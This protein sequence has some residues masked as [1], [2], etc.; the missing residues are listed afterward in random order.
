MII[1]ITG[2]SHTGKTLLAQKMLETYK[3]P[4]LSIDHL[5]MGLIR[6]GQTELTPEDDP[7]LTA[8]LWPIVR[9]SIKTAIENRQNLIVE[10]CYIPF[11]W[12]NDF[13]EAYLKEIK[14]I[15][16]IMAEQYIKQHFSDIVNHA[17]EI[18]YRQDDKDCT[19]ERLLTDNLWYLEMCRRYELPYLLIESDYRTELNI[20]ME[21]I[22]QNRTNECLIIK[23]DESHLPGLEDFYGKVTRHL[24]NTVNYPKWIPGVY[25]GKE[26]ISRAIANQVQYMC[27]YENTIV[28]AFLLNDNPQGDYTKGDW[29]Q[30]LQEGEYLVIHTLAVLPEMSGKGVGRRMVDYCIEKAK[31]GGFKALRMDVVPENIPARKLYE[32]AGFTFAGEKDLQRNLEEIPLFALYEMNF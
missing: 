32:K 17:S 25:P 20:R 28:G 24:N 27:L 30:S 31:A 9:E 22:M 26:S 16:L 14:Y 7:K 3:F 19:A 4:Y 13:E 11:D 5:K 1:L 8:Y 21:S 12:Q 10:G 2:A 6:S 29:Q 15:C 18:E 23:C